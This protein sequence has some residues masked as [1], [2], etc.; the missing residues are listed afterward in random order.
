MLEMLPDAETDD[1]LRARFEWRIPEAYN[2]AVDVCDKWAER[3]PEMPG[4]ERAR[5]EAAGA[6]RA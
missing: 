5:T 4:R 2:I 1:E 3:D 6:D